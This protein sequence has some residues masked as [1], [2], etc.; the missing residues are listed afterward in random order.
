MAKRKKSVKRTRSPKQLKHD[1]CMHVQIPKQRKELLKKPS[2][3]K[4]T[5]IKLHRKAF[6]EAIQACKN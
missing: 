2:N 5:P 6:G 4:L 1:Q 3:R